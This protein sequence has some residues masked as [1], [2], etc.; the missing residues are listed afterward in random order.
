MWCSYYN[1]TT[2]SDAN[3]RARPANRL[4]GNAH[5][6]QVRPSSVLGIFRSWD[7]PVRDDSDEKPRISFLAR[8]VQPAT[9]L[10]KVRVDEEKGALP[11]DS[12]P[13]AATEGRKNHSLP[14]TPRAEPVIAFGGPIPDK[15]SN[16]YATSSGW[17]TTRQLS[18][19]TSWLRHRPPLHPK[20]ASTA[21]S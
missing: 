21:T 19:R 14:F 4:N 20:T 18:R 3:C 7:L 16:L 9:M 13:T 8:E 5:F 11:F 15:T 1:T 2:H 17:R 10:I 6:A 12:A